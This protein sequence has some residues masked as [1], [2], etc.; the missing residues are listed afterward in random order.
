[1]TCANSSQSPV[2]LWP[3]IEA[4]N[5]FVVSPQMSPE[6]TA[7]FWLDTVERAQGELFIATAALVG[8]KEGD[9]G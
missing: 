5:A 9:S 1:M 8:E 6:A 3:W 2:P 7:Q 4:R